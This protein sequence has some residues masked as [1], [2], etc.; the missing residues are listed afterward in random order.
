MIDKLLTQKEI[1]KTF[2]V[3]R[4][5]LWKW[6]RQNLF[7]KAKKIGGRLYWS[8]AKIKNFM[9]SNEVEVKN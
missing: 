5:T 7:P 3:S 4:T 1:M 6:Q 9:E 2:K 8:E